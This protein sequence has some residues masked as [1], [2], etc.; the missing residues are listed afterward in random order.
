MTALKLIQ[1]DDI[2]SLIS[3][4]FPIG[5][6]VMFTYKLQKWQKRNPLSSTEYSS[7]N[8]D[9]LSD[10]ISTVLDFFIK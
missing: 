1:K 9:K 8:D 5:I 6:K 7:L 2:N 4:K 3:N 10:N